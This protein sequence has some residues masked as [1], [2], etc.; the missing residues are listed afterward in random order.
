MKMNRSRRGLA[1]A[2]VL[3]ALAA[4]APP[5]PPRP[6]K[7]QVKIEGMHCEGCAEGI[8]STLGKTRGVLA[9]DVHFSNAVQTV[10]YDAARTAPE[11]VIEAIAKRGF[12][13]TRAAP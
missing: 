10:D 7:L 6:E 5:E 1:A 8:A 2:L 3:A 11:A 9:V 4:C 13:V 12:T